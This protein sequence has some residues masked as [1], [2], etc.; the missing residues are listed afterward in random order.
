MER[1]DAELRQVFLHVSTWLDAGLSF[2]VARHRDAVPGEWRM[3][4]R[5]D[6]L[7]ERFLRGE[8]LRQVPGLVP[9]TLEARALVRGEDPPHEAIAEPLEALADPLDG[10]D[11]GSDAHDHLALA[12]VISAFISRTAS[13]IPVNTA[14]LTIAWP[15]CSSRIPAR[16]A[17]GS[18]FA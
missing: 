7:G 15:M 4:S 3:D 14:R 9:G 11:V 1:C 18:T 13:R 6:R 10:A 17:M 16:A 2:R 12:P 8:S 5:A